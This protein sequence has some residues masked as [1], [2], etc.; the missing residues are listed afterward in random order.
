MPEISDTICAHGRL[1]PESLPV[2]LCI[3]SDYVQSTIVCILRPM[4]TEEYPNKFRDILAR[5]L[6]PQFL[7]H[8]FEPTTGDCIFVL[9]KSFGLMTQA[10][11]EW[12]LFQLQFLS[13]DRCTASCFLL[14]FH[15]P[16]LFYYSKILL[17]LQLLQIFPLHQIWSQLCPKPIPLALH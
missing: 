15:W 3:A 10:G 6:N 12:S 1:V 16:T 14:P 9:S 8:S 4:C 7:D 13:S 2:V 5:Y 17:L 11:L